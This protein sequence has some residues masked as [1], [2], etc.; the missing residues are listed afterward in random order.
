MQEVRRAHQQEGVL[1]QGARGGVFERLGGVHL[2]RTV[3]PCEVGDQRV[4]V[5]FGDE[6]GDAVMDTDVLGRVQLAA[7]LGLAG[8]LQVG[9][10]PLEHK[11]AGPRPRLQQAFVFQR[12]AGL[13]RGGKAD[14]VQPR[15]RPDGRHALAGHQHAGLDGLP[16]VAG[17][18]QVKRLLRQG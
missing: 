11:V 6:V 4:K 8:R 9:A 10:P 13:D 14:L 15:Q 18:P 3:S 2:G 16:V 17:K 7:Q 5:A 1:A 12:V